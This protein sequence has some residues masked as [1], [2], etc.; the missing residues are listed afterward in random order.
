MNVSSILKATVCSFLLFVFAA[1]HAQTNN[2]TIEHVIKKGETLSALAHQYHTTVG[3][4]MRLN[5]M[6]SKSILRI[7]E[8]V[9]IPVKGVVVAQKPVV[10]TSGTAAVQEQTQNNT[11]IHIVAPKETLYAIGKKYKVSVAQ[12]QQWNHFNTT[13]IHTGQQLTIGANATQQPV[14][15]KVAEPIIQPSNIPAITPAKPAPSN[16]TSSVPAN[17]NT[18]QNASATVV[19]NNAPKNQ[20]ISVNNTT[21][22]DNIPAGGFFT[23]YYKQTGQSISGDAS[24]FKTA[25]GWMDKKYYVL[26]NNIPEGTI[27]RIESNQKVVYAK[28]LGA[29][30]N[31]KEDDGLLLRISNAAAAV[32]GMADKRFP[33]TVQY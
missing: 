30:P 18:K 21:N 25:S 6:N 9:K 19:D 8:K 27:V 11:T 14:V 24:I 2:H 23:D 26:I 12:I 7:G 13:N 22:T 5:G 32:L 16:T 1:M 17:Q 10:A 20:V 4:I 15:P 33:V 3:D 28:V 31:I 29:L